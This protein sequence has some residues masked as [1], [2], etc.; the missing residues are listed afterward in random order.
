M[1]SNPFLLYS[2]VEKVKYCVVV[3]DLEKLKQLQTALLFVTSNFIKK[4]CLIMFVSK[5]ADKLIF[6]CL[7]ICCSYL[8]IISSILI[9]KIMFKKYQ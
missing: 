6:V 1:T 9:L 3:N 5:V 2:R 8:C 4:V 7:F